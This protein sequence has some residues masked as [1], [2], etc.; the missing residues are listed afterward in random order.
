MRVTAVE[1]KNETYELIKRSKAVNVFARTFRL[2]LY[3]EFTLLYKS[4]IQ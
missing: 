1:N 3:V 2:F 4:V